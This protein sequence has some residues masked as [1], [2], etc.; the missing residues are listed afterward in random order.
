MLKSYPLGKLRREVSN[1]RQ[2]S[3]RY[4][5]QQ[6]HITITAITYMH[7][8]SY[9]HLCV[10]LSIISRKHYMYISQFSIKLSRVDTQKNHLYGTILSKAN[11]VWFCRNFQKVTCIRSTTVFH[12][13]DSKE[14]QDICFCREMKYR[15]IFVGNASH[16][17]HRIDEVICSH[18][19]GD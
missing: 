17:N 8:C 7:I 2:Q 5:I 15:Q 12:R 14:Q 13:D 11:I 16:C 6:N 1:A 19:S 3:K 10:F 18:L 4:F 9:C